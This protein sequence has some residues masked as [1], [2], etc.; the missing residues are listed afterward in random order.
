MK[1]KHLFFD[2]D[3]TIWDFERNSDENF[4]HIFEKYELSKKG[5]PSIEVFQE[6][7]HIYNSMLWSLYKKGQVPKEVLKT[8]RFELTLLDF[9]INDYL[10]AVNIGNDY[11]ENHTNKNYV[12][13]DAFEVLDYLSK[14]YELHIITNGFDEVQFKKIVSGNLNQYFKNIITSEEAG[15]KKPDAKIFLTA[16]EKANAK[17]EESLMIGDDIEVDIIG[18]GKV[19]MDQVLFNPA[20]TK[21]NEKITYEIKD[22]KELMDI[23]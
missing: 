9:G 13:P 19:G 2:L 21:H 17:V 3:R 1:Y 8:K 11:L 18:A 15:V 5:I 4:A 22:L 14:R 10:M 6:K 12:F 20:G 7:Y 23:L 16:L